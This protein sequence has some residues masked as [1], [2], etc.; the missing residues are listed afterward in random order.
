MVLVFVVSLTLHCCLWSGTA[1]MRMLSHINNTCDVTLFSVLHS[2]LFQS[3]GQ[4]NGRVLVER[5][6]NGMV[7][8]TRLIQIMKKL[9]SNAAGENDP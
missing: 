7:T 6:V 9:R 5:R 8:S 1:V 2:N 4:K 3:C